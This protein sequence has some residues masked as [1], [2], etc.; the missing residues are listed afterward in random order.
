MYYFVMADF[1]T[2]LSHSIVQQF[3]R[4]FEVSQVYHHTSGILI[5]HV[6]WFFIGVSLIYVFDVVVRFIGLGFSSFKA[7]G[8]N[9]FDLIVAG[10][11]LVTVVV[12]QVNGQLGFVM[13][14]LQKLFL[15]SIA[16]K[17]VQR[18]NSL[19]KLF[20]TAMYVFLT[21]RSGMY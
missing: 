19:N 6:D 5:R 1:L 10:G 2:G 3:P 4:K 13:S 7:N 8:W 15:V 17:L 12:A 16:F 18:T 21:E 14:Q 9:I 20:K 11:S